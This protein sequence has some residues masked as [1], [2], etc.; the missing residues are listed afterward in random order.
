MVQTPRIVSEIAQV[1]RRTALSASAITS[2]STFPKSIFN[3]DTATN[4][5]YC[6]QLPLLYVLVFLWIAFLFVYSSLASTFW[7]PLLTMGLFLRLRYHDGSRP[8]L[9]FGNVGEPSGKRCRSRPVENRE[10][11]GHKLHIR[12]GL[13]LGSLRT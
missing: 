2:C 4:R 3:G 6:I 13:Q 8:C 10:I 1:R 9:H 7:I 11:Y 12:C 5:V